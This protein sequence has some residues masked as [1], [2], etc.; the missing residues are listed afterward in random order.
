MKYVVTGKST[1]NLL[2]KL[3]FL[4][5]MTLQDVVSNGVTFNREIDMKTGW[6]F[7]MAGPYEI[8]GHAAHLSLGFEHDKLK[9]VAFSFADEAGSDLQ[10]LRG[11][12]EAFLLKALGQPSEKKPQQA[13]YR[14][15][16]GEIT[17]EFDPRGGSCQILIRWV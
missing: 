12:H 8:A 6:V 17:S 2:L 15:P 4:A 5:G 3:T 16:W 13:I 10:A 7:H 11:K 9:T 1:W 14:Y